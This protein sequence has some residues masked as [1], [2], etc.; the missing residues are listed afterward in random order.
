MG[1]LHMASQSSDARSTQLYWHDKMQSDAWVNHSNS[2]LTCTKK[3][4][5]TYLLCGLIGNECPKQGL[6]AYEVEIQSHR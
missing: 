6:E 3:P 4:L 1:N 5:R 2:R